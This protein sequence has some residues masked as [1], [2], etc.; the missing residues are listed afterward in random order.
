[1]K[2]ARPSISEAEEIV[3]EDPKAQSVTLITGVFQKYLIYLPCSGVLL[4]V[5]SY[6]CYPY[7][8]FCSVCTFSLVQAVNVALL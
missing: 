6:C 2:I 5:K 3:S 1:M 8:M 7:Q 4:L